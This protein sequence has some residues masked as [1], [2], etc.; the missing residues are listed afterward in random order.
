MPRTHH[1]IDFETTLLNGNHP[2][3]VRVE[4]VISSG[5]TTGV[6]IEGVKV[7]NL[8]SR[9]ELVITDEQ[10]NAVRTE[11]FSRVSNPQVK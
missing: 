6:E 9:V 10:M 7:F 5:G 4:A 8:D 11:I 1:F 2:L 3:V